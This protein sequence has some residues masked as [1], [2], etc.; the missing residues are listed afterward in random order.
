VIYAPATAL[1]TSATAYNAITGVKVGDAAKKPV[2]VVSSVVEGLV[3]FD[4]V[5]GV[6]SVDIDTAG[7]YTITYTV[8]DMY[9][10]ETVVDRVL[11]VTDPVV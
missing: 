3:T 7:V 4:P 11:T 2:V 1:T 8:T 6:Y 9:G 10:N 5:T